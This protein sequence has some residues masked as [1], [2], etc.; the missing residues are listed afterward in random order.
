[1]VDTI[2]RITEMVAESGVKGAVQ[3]YDAFNF[4]GFEGEKLMG[5]FHDQ[6][7]MI[8]GTMLENNITN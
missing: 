8:R 3:P 4:N 7:D 2:Q 1:V 6:E 5:E